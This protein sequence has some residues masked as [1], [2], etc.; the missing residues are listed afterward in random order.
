MYTTIVPGLSRPDGARCSVTPEN[1]KP[2]PFGV[3]IG[4]GIEDDAYACALFHLTVLDRPWTEVSKQPAYT[5][6]GIMDV[7]SGRSQPTD[8]PKFHRPWFGIATFACPFLYTV[9][10]VGL[11]AK[12]LA[13]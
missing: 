4:H 11:L 7:A 8:D 1:G 12:C 3:G 6:L 5:I 10:V 9:V 13:T 2:Y